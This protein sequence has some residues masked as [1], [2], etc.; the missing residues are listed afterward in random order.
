M[1]FISD[2]ER[3]IEKIVCIGLR[4]R[5]QRHI[6]VSDTLRL[7]ERKL[8]KRISTYCTKCNEI[9]MRHLDIRKHAS[10]KRWSK[11]YT[12]VVYSFTDK[13]SSA[14]QPMG[15]KFLKCILANLNCT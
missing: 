5:L 13:F 4:I 6:K 7:V 9:N 12:F 11:Y 2:I 3:I 1:L 8:L 10:Y 15:R 14:L